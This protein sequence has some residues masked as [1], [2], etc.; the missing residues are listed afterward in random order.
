MDSFK[1]LLDSGY[2]PKAL[3]LSA[4][5]KLNSTLF[6]VS[7]SSVISLYELLNTSCV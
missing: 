2:V 4:L 5:E 6:L 3:P 1:D 7:Q